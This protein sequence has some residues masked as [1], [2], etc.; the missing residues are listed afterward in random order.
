MKVAFG[1]HQEQALVLAGD[2]AA[3]DEV[4]AGVDVVFHQ[5]GAVAVAHFA[6]RAAD[7]LGHVVHRL[8]AHQVRLTRA[9][10]PVR[11]G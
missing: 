11:G 6:Q 10:W 7:Q 4:G 3:D 1:I 9:G 5:E 2:L 8:H